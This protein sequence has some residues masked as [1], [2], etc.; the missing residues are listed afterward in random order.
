MKHI[1]VC[2][3]TFRRPALLGRLLRELESQKTEGLFTFSIVVADN[4]AGRSSAATVQAHARIS[5]H[6]VTY[7]IEPRQNIALARNQALAH[8]QGDYVAFIDD[9]EF[10]TADWLLRLVTTC[11]QNG[12]AGVLGPVRP[13]FDAPPPQWIIDGGFCERPEHPTG[14]LMPWDESRTGNLLFRRAIIGHERH[15][16]DP[17]FACGGE[18][19]DFFMRMA[20]RGHLFCWCNEAI[21]YETVPPDRW[22]RGYMLRRALLRGRNILKHPIGR[23]PLLARSLVAVPVYSLALPITLPF[24]QHVFMKYCIRFCDH[25]GR[26]LALFGLNWVSER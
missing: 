26:I 14:H 8:A 17:A 10:P 9:D 13:H 12:V 3:C 6:P 16:F 25:I 1:T 23:G 5:R 11:E 19:K 2:I 22:T 24:G 21:A 4:D 15:P 7:C 18:D 20:Q